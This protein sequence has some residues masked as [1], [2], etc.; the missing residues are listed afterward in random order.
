V[1]VSV[2][3]PGRALFTV[4]AKDREKDAAKPL[5]DGSGKPAPGNLQCKSSEPAVAPV[6]SAASA[7]AAK[8]PLLAPG[9][10]ASVEPAKPLKDS[11]NSPAPGNVMR[12]KSQ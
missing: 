2:R 6:E 8:K 1:K 11:R 4:R 9:V 5:L 3:T 7:T 12:K 10:A